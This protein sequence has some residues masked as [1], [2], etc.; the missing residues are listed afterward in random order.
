MHL[1]RLEIQGFKTFAQ[2]TVFVFVEP[3]DGSGGLTVVVG[4]NGSGK[5]NTADAIRWVMGEQSLRL[6]R[7]KSSDDVIFSGSATKSR[8]GFAEVSLVLEN[9]DH[10]D[11]AFSE[12]T[13]TRRLDRDGRSEYEINGEQAKLSDVSLLLA[14]IGI[15]QRSYAVIGQGMVDHV[16]TASP[17]ERKAFFDEAFG[18]RPFHLRREQALRKMTEARENLDKSHMLIRE[19]EPRVQTLRKQVERYQERSTW[20]TTLRELEERWYGSEWRRLRREAARVEEEARAI[21]AEEKKIEI[22]SEF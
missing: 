8:S 21:H 9:N 19:L 3:K 6:L 13:L 2:K 20:E 22:A 12:I 4:P 14:Q 1:K 11:I 10:P 7:G 18:L 16:L 17:S 5:S 15:A